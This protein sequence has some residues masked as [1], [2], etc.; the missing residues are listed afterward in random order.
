MAARD[1]WLIGRESGLGDAQ[2]H[3]PRSA[4]LACAARGKRVSADAPAVRRYCLLRSRW[5]RKHRYRLRG[6]SRRA[7]GTAVSGISHRPSP[8]GTP[9]PPSPPAPPSRPPRL[10]GCPRRAHLRRPR[11]TRRRRLGRRLAPGLPSAPFSPGV[12]AAPVIERTWRPPPAGRAGGR[13]AA[14]RTSLCCASIGGASPIQGEWSPAA[15]YGYLA[16]LTSRLASQSIGRSMSEPLRWQVGDVRIT[17]VQELEAPD[18][19]FVIAEATVENL[20]EIEW[21]GPFRAPNGHAL[22]SVH[23]L[24]LEVGERRIAV[25]TCIG[26]DKPRPIPGWNMLQRSVPRRSRQGRLP[27]QSDRHGD[28]H[29]PPHRPRRLE[30]AARRRA[31]GPHLPQRALPARAAASGSTGRPTP[32]RSIRPCSPTRCGRSSTPASSTSW[33][34]ITPSTRR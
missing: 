31:L 13:R 27:A 17:R 20:A 10:P 6:R 4:R 32:T 1:R 11:P 15:G 19:R 8:S 30:H 23:T 14:R 2:P 26:N 22:A 18:L 7:A 24:I 34:W 3:R 25:D 28:L 12:P 21:L 5:P 29:P 16:I 9:L 33:R